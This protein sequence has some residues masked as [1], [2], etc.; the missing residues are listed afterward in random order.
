MRPKTNEQLRAIFGLGKKLNCE[1]A[2][3]EE[4]A[5][6]IT[7]G[8]VERLS[9]LSFDEANALIKRLGGDPV[10]AK[11]SAPRRTVN[12]RKQKAGVPTLAGPYHLAK[13]DR[14]AADRGM[15][16][17]GLERMCMRMLRSKRPRTAQGCNAVIEALKAMNR[18][19]AKRRAA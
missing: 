15:S 16:P 8:R 9:M 6:D 10:S 11:P 7:S 5:A 14:L 18:R 13:M 12:Y 19:D 17:E 2:D 1:K 4:M 3:L